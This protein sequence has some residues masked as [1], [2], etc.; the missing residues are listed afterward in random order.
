MDSALDF[1]SRGCGFESHLGL[2]IAEY[3][4]ILYIPAGEIF[5]HLS[6]NDKEK[7]KRTFVEMDEW[8][9]F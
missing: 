2:V 1:E 9:C 4:C 8:N 7:I 3:L 5:L 6:I